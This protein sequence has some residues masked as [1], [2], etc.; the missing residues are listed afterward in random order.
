MAELAVR[1][2]EADPVVAAA[3]VAVVVLAQE[4]PSAFV[5]AAL[6]CVAALDWQILAVVVA[7]VVGVA[8]P[9]SCL[10]DS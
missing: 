6:D 2:V 8:V 5:V 1:V 3:E 9:S 10:V 7:A 4:Q